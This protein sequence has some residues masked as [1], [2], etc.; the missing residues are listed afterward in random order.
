MYY[1]GLQIIK[2]FLFYRDHTK[3]KQKQLTERLNQQTK[4]NSSKTRYK[5]REP[6]SKNKGIS[7]LQNYHT[8]IIEAYRTF[9]RHM[10]SGATKRPVFFIYCERFATSS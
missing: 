4:Y 1:K 10:R 6:T 9:K 7:L 2:Q 5:A 8:G 3:Q